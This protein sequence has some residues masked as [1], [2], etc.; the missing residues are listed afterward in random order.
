VTKKTVK[1][2]RSFTY[3]R[4]SVEFFKSCLI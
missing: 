4:F 1:I 3:N 2:G